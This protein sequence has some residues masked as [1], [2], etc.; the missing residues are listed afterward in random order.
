VHLCAGDFL[1][2]FHTSVG[3]VR[4]LFEEVGFQWLL[5]APQQHVGLISSED[6]LLVLGEVD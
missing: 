3:A 6:I 2:L 4:E 1:S 5:D